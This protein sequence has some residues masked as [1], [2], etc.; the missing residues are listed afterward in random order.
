[1]TWY[2]LTRD[3]VTKPSALREYLTAVDWAKIFHWLAHIGLMV[4]AVYIQTHPELA[5]YAP[6]LQAIGQSMNSP[7]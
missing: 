6:V 7:K 1:M 2:S 3:P 4:S 5:P